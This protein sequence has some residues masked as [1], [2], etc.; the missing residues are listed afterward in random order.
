MF[1]I[2][3]P[4]VMKT[5]Q[6][7]RCKQCRYSKTCQTSMRLLE[8]GSPPHFLISGNGIRF[9][10]DPKRI[11]KNRPTAATAHGLAMRRKRWAKGTLQSSFL[12]MV[13]SPSVR[14]KG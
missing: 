10:K 12:L 11:E 6:I 3:E 14:S 8:E 9:V 2:D 4:V 5:G 7:N 13:T 1:H